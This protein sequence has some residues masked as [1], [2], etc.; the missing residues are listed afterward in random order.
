MTSGTVDAKSIAFK[1]FGGYQFNRYLGA[2]LAYV[3]LGN[4]VYSGEFSGTPVTNGKVGVKGLDVSAIRTVALSEKVS[5][6]GT[7]G[8]FIWEAHATDIAPGATFIATCVPSW[9]ASRL[10]MT[11]SRSARAVIPPVIVCKSWNQRC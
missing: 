11:R 10:A 3:D 6:F 5:A 2:E 8:L 9:R 1:F 7:L 4:L